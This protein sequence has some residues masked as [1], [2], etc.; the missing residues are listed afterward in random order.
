MSEERVQYDVQAAEDRLRALAATYKAAMTDDDVRVELRVDLADDLTAILDALAAE[1]KARQTAERER[2]RLADQSQTLDD[3]NET[4]HADVMRLEKDLHTVLNVLATRTDQRD[5]L[6]AEAAG[7]RAVG[8]AVKA[9]FDGRNM[10]AFPNAPH[11]YVV[12]GE[13]LDAVKAALGAGE[14]A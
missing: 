14:L 3:I 7:L 4:L 12:D 5:T 13:A 10:A 9:L 8:A 2:D 1:R 11:C 6:A